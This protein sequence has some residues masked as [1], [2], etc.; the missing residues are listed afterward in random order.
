M[1]LRFF[2][3]TM[4][5]ISSCGKPTKYN[6][7]ASVEALKSH[8]RFLASE[9]LAGRATGSDGNRKAAA[10]IET[11]FRTN[12]LKR[13]ADSYLQNF[14]VTTAVETGANTRA[15]V[16]SG[17]VDRQLVLGEEF[18]PLSLS[19]TG[20]IA[21]KLVFAGF[22]ISAPEKNYDD[23]QKIDVSG[24]I[25][26]VLR[27]TPDGENPH[28]ELAD[29]GRDGGKVRT[30]REKGA[31]GIILVNAAHQDDGLMPLAVTYPQEYEEIAVL[32]LSRAAIAPLF[33]DKRTLK[34][35]EYAITETK[36]SASFEIPNAHFSADIELDFEKATSSNVVGY[37]AGTDPALKD[38][39][40]VIGAHYDHLGMGGHGSRSENEQPAIH[41][42]ADDNASGT[43][44]VLALA[45][46]TARKPLARPVI[47][48]AFSG[49][50]LGLL[51]STY[52]CDNPLIPLENII[53]MLNM[54]MIGRMTENKV[55]ISGTGTASHFD[56]LVDAVGTALNLTISKSADGFGP[57]DHSAFYGR[58]IPV[59]ALFSGL[60]DDYH[61]PTDT[62]DKINFEGVRNLTLAAGA[63]LDSIS[64]A[65]EKPQF[66]KVQSSGNNGRQMRFRVWVGTIPDYSDHPLG[67]RITGVR[68]GSPAAKGGMTGGDIIVKFGQDSVKTIYDYTYALGKYKP[69]DEVTVEVL[70]GDNNRPVTLSIILE[71]RQ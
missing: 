57:S 45:S 38:Q 18:T 6:D 68:E 29:Y 26:V 15:V 61:R 48:I 17:D 58:N 2:I 41:F 30:A 24:K 67:M 25:V 53:A 60:H 62:W 16:T 66:V 35:L 8:I 49:E 31:V 13:F 21:G 7:P 34:D 43:A 52:F 19:K 40:I 54:D 42:G 39:F 56:Q 1:I 32:C 37:V 70:R 23:Y 27:E 50:E 10:Y 12:G 22:G 63:M 59:L 64:T 11:F 55:T 69:G 28:G 36:K 3:L 20:R 51:G 71:K 65:A 46:L 44:G 5:L 4:L 47:F 33:P 14:T 9:D